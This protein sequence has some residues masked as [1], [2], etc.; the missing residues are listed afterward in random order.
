[1][2]LASLR[3]GEDCLS[4]YQ[5][6]VTEWGYLVWSPSGVVAIKVVMGVHGDK[7]VE[8]GGTSGG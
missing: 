3:E 2:H 4:Q 6:N 7:A 8:W 5:D 1:M